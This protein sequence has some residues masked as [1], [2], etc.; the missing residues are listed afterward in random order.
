MLPGKSFKPEDILEILRR[1]YWLVLVP[2][3]VCAAGTSVYTRMLPDLYQSIALIS[4]VPP[5]VPLGMVP[6]ASSTAG[7]LEQ[8]IPQIKNEILSRTRLERIVQDLDLYP[9]ERRV[10]I[11]ED[12]VERM[13]DDVIVESMAGSAINVGFIARDGKTAFRVADRLSGLFIDES[14]KD[15][16]LMLEGTDQFLDMSLKEA[17]EKLL[18][19][20]KAMNEY[21][22][23][24]NGELPENLQANLSAAQ[25]T[26]QQITTLGQSLDRQGEQKLLLDKSIAE[27]EAQ[28]DSLAYDP[29]V[30]PVTETSKQLA[31]ARAQLQKQRET[32]TDAHPAVK[33]TLAQI[34]VLQKKLEDETANAPVSAGGQPVSAAERTRLATLRDRRETLERLKT[35]ITRDEGTLGE[36]RKK[37]AQY[38]QRAES[39]STHQTAMTGINRDYG[40][41][42][43]SYQDLR[44]QKE[45]T[46]LATNLERREI[47]EQFKLID[48]AREP[49]APF[50]PKRERTNLLGMAAG[51]L[52][53]L[54]VIGLLEYRDST[55]KT[56]ED[57]SRVLG[58]PVLAVVPLMQSDVERRRAWRRRLAT[59][60]VLGSVVVGC[61]AVTAYAFLR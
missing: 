13:R 22:Q 15:R 47:G 31:A 39:A 4:V 57:L 27:L 20:E 59:S 23:Q 51:L 14:T 52:L 16:K 12:I 11:M 60:A 9:D 34:A 25:T 36:L 5:K 44:S 19:K 33:S 40:I 61:L 18:E 41:L 48:K 35:Q 17:E 50:A 7:T 42:N 49:G 30:G 28:A 53:G 26:M 37:L 32:L 24:H 56:D 10:G 58:M 46:G 45:Q 29:S 8:R 1:R 2:F 55:F 38:Q 6:A 21:R 43:K 3:A 54:A